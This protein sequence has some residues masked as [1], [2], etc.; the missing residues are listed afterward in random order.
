MANHPW[1]VIAFSLFMAVGCPE[2][3]SPDDDV[4]E[5]DD[6]TDDDD[7]TGDDDTTDADGDGYT[8]QDGDCDDENGDVYP[9]AE[10]HWYDGIDSDCDGEE[11][12]DPCDDPPPESTVY[13]DPACT[14]EPTVG[15]FNPT[16]GWSMSSFVDYPDHLNTYST[17]VVGQLTDDTGDGNINY[18]DIPDIAV[19]QGDA[20]NGGMNGVIRLISGDGTAV[21]WS[22]HDV[23]WD[24][25]TY[26]TYRYS[27][28]ALG[29]IDGDGLGDLAVTVV[30]GTS[31]CYAAAFDNQ[32]QLKWV[33]TATAVGCRNN[34]PAIHDL[35]GDGDVEVVLGRLILNGGDGSLQGVGTGGQGY[36]ADYSN[37]GYHSVGVDLDGDGVMEVIAGSEVY[38]PLGN[39]LCSTG[40]AD[41]YPAVADLDG[42]G[43]G[44]FVVSG[45]SAVR[46]FEDDCS[47]IIGWNTSDGGKGGPPT[48]A[49]FDGDGD[50]E[51]AIAS[52]YY[53][54]VYE[55]DGSERWSNPVVDASSNSTGSSVFDFD[56]DGRA[57]VVYADETRL[58]V[59]DGTNGDILLEDA[60]HT[61]GTIN[62]YPTIAD[63][64]RDGN[65]E[66]VVANSAG[67]YGLYVIADANDEWVSARPVW[68]QQGFYVTNIEDD[69]SVP[70]PATSNWPSYNNFRQGAP[71]SFEALAAPNVYPLAYGPCQESA[72]TPVEILIQVANDG[73]ILAADD[74]V[75]AIYGVD[76]MN[77]RTLLASYP[78]GSPLFSG[79]LSA[80]IS[81]QFGPGQLAGYLQLA[82]VVDDEAAANE[83]DE[84][85][86]E[87]L[88]DLST[89]QR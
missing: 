50:L 12:P 67:N 20:V 88:I 81:L 78:L 52:I 54:V 40:Y 46:L 69:L 83:C 87:A 8:V 73:L 64:D 56:G 39:T 36:H 26:Y 23:V 27:G 61:S 77:D 35:E 82:V 4:S 74:L 48:I 47:Y 34:Y 2:P 71:G 7:T 85:D 18:R 16:T 15:S 79:V 25:V 55:Q 66:I 43:R 60:G 22:V 89:V 29:D 9:G 31:T 63:V 62:E 28:V 58:W 1:T 70:S 32:G 13:V 49:D 11:N 38:D 44:E 84:M 42:D 30:D 14:Y 37:S 10:E 45:N 76:P 6:S 59:Y 72:G 51:I 86:N 57:E 33:H 3:W 75:V 5:D 21:H 17:P 19:S 68:N 24:S 80:P 41:G 65:A 53:Y